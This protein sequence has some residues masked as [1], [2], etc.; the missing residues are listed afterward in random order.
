MSG[1]ARHTRSNFRF[2]AHLWTRKSLSNVKILAS[3]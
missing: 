1:D 2:R 3:W